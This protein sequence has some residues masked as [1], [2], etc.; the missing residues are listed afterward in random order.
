MQIGDL[1]LVKRVAWKGRYKIQN[2]WEQSEYVIVD[3]PNKNVPVYKV[4]SLEDGKER[5][6]HRNMLLPLVIK[7]FPEQES[8]HDSEQEE[9]PEFE[10]CHVERQIPEEISQPIDITDMT[11]VAQSNLEH[12]QENNS[13][14]IEHV[15]VALWP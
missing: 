10:Q 13:S 2:K 3:Q 8:D 15:D 5:I 7:F 14:K 6:L 1:V 12:G 11:P 4:K 9:E